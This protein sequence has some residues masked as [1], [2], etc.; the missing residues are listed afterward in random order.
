MV[1][2][3]TQENAAFLCT[4]VMRGCVHCMDQDRSA[5]G[6]PI[7]QGF[8]TWVRRDRRIERRRSNGAPHFFS[9]W[10]FSG[11]TPIRLS[12][13]AHGAPYRTRLNSLSPLHGQFRT[14]LCGYPRSVSAFRLSESRTRSVLYERGPP[15]V[16]TPLSSVREY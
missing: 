15:L 7:G 11:M 16:G 1:T 5:F 13:H 3:R 8:S 4:T 9:P 12:V 10:E 2:I 6:C 14:L